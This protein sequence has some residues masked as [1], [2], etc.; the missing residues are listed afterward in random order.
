[1]NQTAARFKPI[2]TNLPS[3][4]HLAYPFPVDT[5]ST[6]PHDW[7]QALDRSRADLAAGR[8][9]DGA[10]F[11]SRL[12]G[13]LKQMAAAPAPEPQPGPDLPPSPKAAE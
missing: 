10:A 7:L 3:R 2:Q 12:R 9:V 8:V 13:S 6:A 1:M 5:P 11:R 4:P